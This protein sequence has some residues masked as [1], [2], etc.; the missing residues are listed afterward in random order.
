MKPLPNPSDVV[1]ID[2][3]E[4]PTS[5][6]KGEGLYEWRHLK[7][8]YS[9]DF[10]DLLKEI[11]EFLPGRGEEVVERLM[12]FPRVFLVRSTG[13]VISDAIPTED[14]THPVGLFGW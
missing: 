12:N 8:K 9:L 14:S 3:I 13:E 6:D 5:R 11:E 10:L 7:K 2:R 4:A 1:R